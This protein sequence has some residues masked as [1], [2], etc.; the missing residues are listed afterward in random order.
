MILSSYILLYYITNSILYVNIPYGV[1]HTMVCFGNTSTI[2]LSQNCH[3]MKYQRINNNNTSAFLHHM[4]KHENNSK[5]FKIIYYYLNNT[6]LDTNWIKNSQRGE[7]F[8]FTENE[9]ITSF[10][11]EN[12]QQFTCKILGILNLVLSSLIFSVLM[13]ISIMY[14]KYI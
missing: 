6:I 3:Y 11:N 5:F 8:N 13:I 7:N 4:E 14:Y 2:T 10:K 9:N 12:L 1:K